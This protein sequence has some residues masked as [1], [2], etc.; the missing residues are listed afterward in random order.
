M[1][2]RLA[3]PLVPALAIAIAA[4]ASG[5]GSE[6]EG[7]SAT[8]R[9]SAEKE[10]TRA[11][12]LRKA[13]AG[14]RRERQ[15]LEREVSRFLRLQRGRKPPRELYAD[16]AQLVILPAIE[17]EMEAVRALG[18][19][20]GPPSEERKVDRLLYAEEIALNEL[21]L[22]DEVASRKAIERK[23]TRSGRRLAAYGLPDCANGI[24]RTG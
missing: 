3:A 15:G 20:P 12:Y 13:N 2:T 6:G 16:L 9:P 7:D 1:S 23:F 11:A 21:A 10:L 14:C 5:C 19:P 24:P 17:S 18:A 8:A 4:L 22:T